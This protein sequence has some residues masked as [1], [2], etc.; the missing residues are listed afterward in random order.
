M[1]E[2]IVNIEKKYVKQIVNQKINIYNEKKNVDNIAMI[3]NKYL[4]A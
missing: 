2:S 1:I 4:Y 3:E